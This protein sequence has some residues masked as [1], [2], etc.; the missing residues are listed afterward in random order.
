MRHYD[1]CDRVRGW[2]HDDET[3]KMKQYMYLLSGVCC[4]GVER[5]DVK[6]VVLCLLG[7]LVECM[8]EWRSAF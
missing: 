7:V 4:D 2:D 3:D 8:V 5:G 1:A 6:G